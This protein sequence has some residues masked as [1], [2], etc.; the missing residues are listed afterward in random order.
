MAGIVEGMVPGLL[1]KRTFKQQA[2]TTEL[3]G[4]WI[5]EASPKA[6][7]LAQRVMADR[8]DQTTLLPTLKVKTHLWA[9]QEDALIPNTESQ[10]MAQALPS[11]ELKIFEGVGDLIPLEDP[12]AFQNAINQI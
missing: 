9:G 11:C 2:A 12:Q 8:R 5:K 10:T 3:V 6:V 4:R 7:A 1:G